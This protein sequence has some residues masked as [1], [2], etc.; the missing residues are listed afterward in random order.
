LSM[1]MPAQAAFWAVRAD[2]IRH[3]LIPLSLQCHS[4]K[5]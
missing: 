2:H 4:A 5:A 3:W 1:W